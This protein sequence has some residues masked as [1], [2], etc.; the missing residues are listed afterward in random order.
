MKT[1]IPLVWL[2]CTAACA[3]FLSAQPL[4]AEVTPVQTVQFAGDTEGTFTDLLLDDFQLNIDEALTGFQKFDPALGTLTEIRITAEVR[5]TFNL[6]VSADE[7]EDVDSP[8]TVRFEDQVSDVLQA[9]VS[10][11]PT[12]ENFARVLTFDTENPGSAGVEDED[13]TDWG[14]PE[15]F[16]FWDSTEREFGGFA[17]EGDTPSEGSLSTSD[18]DINL[19]D[20]V[21]TGMVEGLSFFYIAILANTGVMENVPAAYLEVEIGLDPGAVMLQYVYTPAAPSVPTRITGYTKSGTNHTILF[22]GEAGR[23]DWAVKGGNDLIAFGTD[24]TAAATIIETA[25]G[26][27]QVLLSLPELAEPRYF[28]RIEE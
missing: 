17:N 16:Y 1:Q 2:A 23:S 3:L 14:A 28:F 11:S 27:Y 26:V 6:T 9:G 8:F 4:H 21:G 24:H 5:A 10:Y 15:D 20:F 13:P 19:N 22:T 25:A 12:G 7:V 18:P